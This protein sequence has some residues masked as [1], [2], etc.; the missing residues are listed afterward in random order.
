[1][2]TLFKLINKI[3]P[4]EFSATRDASEIA[5][6]GGV[7]KMIKS[8]LLSEAKFLHNFEKLLRL[9]ILSDL[10]VLFLLL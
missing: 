3:M 5:P 1:M 10:V 7:S 6:T 2:S 9:I 4:S 8:Y